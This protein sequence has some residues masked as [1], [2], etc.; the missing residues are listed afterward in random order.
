[1]QAV[2]PRCAHPAANPERVDQLSCWLS[3]LDLSHNQLTEVPP[4]LNQL[5]R[6]PRGVPATGLPARR[7][8]VE[9]GTPDPC[10]P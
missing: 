9:W 1:M 4:V 6:I 10:M 3:Q 5:H 2:Y 8:S 7:E